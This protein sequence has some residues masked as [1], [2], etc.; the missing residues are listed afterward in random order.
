M[1][2]RRG[3]MGPTHGAVKSV[4]EENEAVQVA[5][6]WR[7]PLLP[8]RHRGGAAAPS[9]PACPPPEV[10]AAAEEMQTELTAPQDV[11]SVVEG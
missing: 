9:P 8:P 2:P 1:R 10:V 11:V 6:G 7:S 3:Q 4:A 5:K